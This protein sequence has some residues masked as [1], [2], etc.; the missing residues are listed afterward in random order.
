MTGSGR[1]KRGAANSS[2]STKERLKD[3]KDG[4]RESG[5]VEGQPA[6]DCPHLYM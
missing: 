1:R 2:Q 4:G 6:L 3:E 5:E